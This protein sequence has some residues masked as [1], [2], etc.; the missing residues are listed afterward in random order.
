MSI[1]F[2]C[3]S[4]DH[5]R[6]EGDQRRRQDS[7]SLV[8]LLHGEGKNNLMKVTGVFQHKSQRNGLMS[9]HQT[10]VIEVQKH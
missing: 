2:F 5:E 4:G 6:S 7:S 3:W 1:L 9:K 10:D 8:H